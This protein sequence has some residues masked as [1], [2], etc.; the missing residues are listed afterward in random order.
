MPNEESHNADRPLTKA[1]AEQLF[2]TKA[3]L[4]RFA[5]KED[6]EQR[7]ATE[8][9]LE[10]ALG[11]TEKRMEQR[12]ATKDDL[13]NGL[14]NLKEEMEQLISDQ[15]T[16]ILEAVDEKLD[17]K[18]NEKLDPVIITLDKVLKEVQAHREEDIAGAAQLRRHD[19]ELKDHAEQLKGY[20][21]RIRVLEAA[22]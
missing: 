2:A 22:A 17:K 20:E 18:F 3:D 14:H 5:T 11:A 19:D 6:L 1:E 15:A 8:A 16:V 13:H 9:D 10:R 12:F 21:Q 7:F 4:E